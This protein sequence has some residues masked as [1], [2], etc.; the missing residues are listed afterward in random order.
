MGLAVYRG[1]ALGSRF[2]RVG[3]SFGRVQG[4]LSRDRLLIDAIRHTAA[5]VWILGLLSSGPTQQQAAVP[6]CGASKK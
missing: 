5:A 1:I 4:M 3:R 2:T 6:R